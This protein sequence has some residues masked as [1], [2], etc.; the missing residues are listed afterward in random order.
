LDPFAQTA[1]LNLTQFVDSDELSETHNSD[2]HLSDEW[3]G[4]FIGP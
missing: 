3:I 4:E 2:S 1:N